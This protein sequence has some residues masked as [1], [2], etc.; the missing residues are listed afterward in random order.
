M[1]KIF[2]YKT[3]FAFIF[4]AI[5]A[6]ANF[7]TGSWIENHYPN[8]Q[9]SPD[10]LLNNLPYV[11][12]F[13]IISELSLF[14]GL[15]L[16]AFLASTS[17]KLRLPYFVTNLATVYAA[18]AILITLTPLA[19]TSP[20]KDQPNFYGVTYSGMFPSGHIA[21]ATI[22]FLLVRRYG[23]NLLA[24]QVS[25]VLVV[26]QGVSLLL[27]HG[28]YSIDLIGGMMLAYVTYRWLLR[29]E[30]QLSIG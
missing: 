28:H 10:L 7:K 3:A 20:L 13:N 9:I 15:V 18:R 25:A 17:L 12:I 8:E 26:L 21:L 4:L 5:A 6:I 16:L 22:I 1:K 19:Q 30:R 24:T 14:A 11:P 23:S 29:F 27:S 2:H